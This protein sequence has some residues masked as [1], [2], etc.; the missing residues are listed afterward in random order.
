MLPRALVLCTLLFAPIVHASDDGDHIDRT[1][2]IQ[3]PY[4]LIEGEADPSV[5]RLPLE[6]TDVDITVAGV[7]ADVRVRQFYVNTGTQP[8]NT[9][10]VFPGSTRAAVHGLL[11]RV[12]ERQVRAQIRERQQAQREFD[13]AK[14]EGKTASLLAEERPNVFTMS[15]ANVMPGDRIEV[16][17]H[18]SELL[19]PQDGVYEVVFPTVVGP[20][21]VGPASPPERWPSTPIARPGAE[22]RTGFALRARVSAGTPVVDLM[23]PSHFIEAKPDVTGV[24]QVTLPEGNGGTRD[25]ILR[26]RLA[27]GSVA[28]GLL[29]S[30]PQEGEGFFLLTVDPPKRVEPKLVPPRDYLFVVDVSGSMAGFPLE[31]AKRVLVELART[32]KPTDT[33]NILFF[34]GGSQT[35]APRSL[36]ATAH[37]LERGLKMLSDLPGGGGTE[38]LPAL[39]EA[40]ALP[41]TP[42]LSR[43]VLVVTDGYVTVERE[44]LEL[45]SRH[46]GEANLFALGVGSSVNRYL[47]EALAHAGRGAPFIVTDPSQA[48]HIAQQLSATIA[49]PVL[50]NVKVAFDGFEVSEVEPSAVPDVLA[51]RP[52]VI[53]GKW[54]GAPRGT[55]TVSGVTGAGRWSQTFDVSKVTPRPEHEALRFLWARERVARLSDYAAVATPSAEEVAEVTALGLRHGLLTKYTSFVAVLEQ[56][57]NAGAAAV[58]VE[59]P[60]PLPDG[61]GEAAVGET[62]GDEP[63]FLWVAALAMLVVAV[64]ALRGRVGLRDLVALRGSRG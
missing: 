53:H 29:L 59:Q 34:S 25:F 33:F 55:V 60:L 9:R 42:G 58:D 46:L 43:T 27:S 45:I 11:L 23:S 41:K 10:Y 20:R 2:R 64:N 7:I 31:T 61:V 18:Y 62:H 50:S 13:Q 6:A 28:S 35:L 51:S 3:A 1:D 8:I 49:T 14:R 5:D 30:E 36:P 38:L 48:D 17:L 44:A 24:T 47:I 12:G 21:Y 22:P 16:Q 52:V 19:V 4:F 39:G 32:L 40:F 15:L 63:P 57:R 54:R 37:N 26:Y 56:V